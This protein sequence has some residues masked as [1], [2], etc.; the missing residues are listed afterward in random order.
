MEAER[1]PGSALPPTAPAERIGA[2]DVLRGFA[3]F[4]VFMVNASVVARPFA[5][6]VAPP[7]AGSEL[8]AWVLLNGVFVT[9]FVALFSLL[10]GMGLVLQCTRIEAR[11]ESA[12]LYLRKLGWLGCFGLM[13][14]CLLF[15]GDI[16]LPYALFGLVLFFLR[17]RSPAF[18]IRAALL[19]Y[20]A[21]LVLEAL[22]ALEPQALAD[23]ELEALEA[24]AHAGGSLALLVRVRT[25][26]YAGWLFL[27][28]VTL[29]NAQVLALFFLGA[30]LMKLGWLEGPP[31]RFR[32][33]AFAGL[34][35][36]AL[37][38]LCA[39]LLHDAQ[40]AGARVASQ[41]LFALGA[42]ALAGGYAGAVVAAVR[43]SR[44]PRVQR[45]LAAAGRTALT[46]YVAQSV[47]MNLVFQPFGLDL[48]NELSRWEVLA[49]VGFLYGLQVGAAVLWLEHFEQGPLEWV[50]RR[51]TYGRPVAF[52]RSPSRRHRSCSGP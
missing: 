4:G 37:L 36:G 33:T 23:P 5:E 32:R 22:V 17:R 11:G 7:D 10:F 44:F 24:R 13:H 27:S 43:A 6:A 38:E 45:A 21:G 2:L 15:E 39:L 50:W 1:D 16:L 30:A 9:K 25:L 29:F 34:L 49:L 14:G 8:V 51:V 31:A 52:L 19:V 48:W 3:L 42:L 47:L 18:L 12:R 40:S 41:L 28:S 46:G 26:Q 35:A 20:L